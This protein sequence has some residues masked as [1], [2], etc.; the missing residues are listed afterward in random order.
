MIGA[1]AE[2]SQMKREM[3]ESKARDERQA[4][5]SPEHRILTKEDHAQPSQE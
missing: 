2:R 3:D 4:G 5:S 1:R